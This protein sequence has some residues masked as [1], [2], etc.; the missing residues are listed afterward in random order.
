MKENAISKEIEITINNRVKTFNEK[1]LPKNAVG[2]CIANVKGKF[3]YIHYFYPKNKRLDPVGR[4]TYN[5]D[6]DDMP[7]A[8]FKYS[9]ESYSFNEFFPGQEHLNGTIEGALKAVLKAYEI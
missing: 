9:S 7:F 2:H 3:I 8:I 1:Y 5:G 4:L 6:L